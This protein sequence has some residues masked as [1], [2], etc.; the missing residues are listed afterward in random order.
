MT[1]RKL[2]DGT[3]ERTVPVTGGGLFLRQPARIAEA[4]R[5]RRDGLSYA[6]IGRA[7]GCSNWT[8]WHLVHPERYLLR[9]PGG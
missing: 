6:A 9:R 2:A 4:K 8:A 7:M 1:V 5:L 3:T